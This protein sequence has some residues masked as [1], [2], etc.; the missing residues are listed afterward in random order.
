MYNSYIGESLSSLIPG[1]FAIIQ[2]IGVEDKC[3]S[4]NNATNSSSAVQAGTHNLK[5]AF[6]VS[7]YFI[8]MLFLLFGSTSAFTYLNYSKTALRTR[9]TYINR[10]NEINLSQI[11][12]VEE[13]LA[14]EAPVEKKN[15][16][17][18]L[19]LTFAGSFIQ[20][21]Y[22]PGLLSYSTIPYGNT[23]FHLSINLSKLE[24]TQ[25]LCCRF[26]N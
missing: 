2:S 17:T 9:K 6:S 10:T 25:E 3:P 16:F 7:I 15:I 26:V 4:F 23:F 13:E 5:P 20:Y 11:N 22:L 1:L 8:I 19:C 14:I 18:L 12:L 24:W 21:G